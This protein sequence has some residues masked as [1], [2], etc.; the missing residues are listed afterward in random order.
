[1]GFSSPSCNDMKDYFSP[2]CL[3]KT[4][5]VDF[6]NLTPLYQKILLMLFF[7]D[8]LHEVAKRSP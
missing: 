5:N 2:A 6:V 1:M 7:G 8:Q 3:F 4:S